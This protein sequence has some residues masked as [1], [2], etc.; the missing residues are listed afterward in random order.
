MALRRGWDQLRVPLQQSRT[1]VPAQDRV[2]VAGRPARL[3]LLVPASRLAQELVDGALGARSRLAEQRARAPLAN[4]AGVVGAL[5]AVL[6]AAKCLPCPRDG[7]GAVLAE[8][9]RQRQDQPDQGRLTLR[10]DVEDVEVDVLGLPGLAEQP[11]A[12][13]LRERARY[14]IL[15]EQL[16]LEHNPVP[17]GAAR[18]P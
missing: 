13:A 18:L 5:V 8:L 4:D 16:E 2:V 14:P 17:V 6:D 9:V 12:L 11:V 7:R 1:R 15:R 3:G 10:I